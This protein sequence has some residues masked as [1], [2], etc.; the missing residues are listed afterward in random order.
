M[1][2]RNGLQIKKRMGR[3]LLLLSGILFMSQLSVAGDHED[4]IP[5]SNHFIHRLGTEVRTG[6]YHPD[7]SI[8]ERRKQPIESA[9]E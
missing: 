9:P 2:V 1:T 8:P 5:L 4:S 7:K 6:I 3:K